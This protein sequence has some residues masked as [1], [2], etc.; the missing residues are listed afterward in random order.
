VNVFPWYWSRAARD[1][2][3]YSLCRLLDSLVDTVMWATRGSSSQGVDSDKLAGLNKS[4][5]DL[6]TSL[7][8]SD[9]LGKRMVQAGLFGGV[10]EVCCAS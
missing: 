3:L 5:D 1:T 9:L 8:D 4:L 6:A 10:A 2:M 7:G